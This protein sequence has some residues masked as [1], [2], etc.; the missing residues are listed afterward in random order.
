MYL[1][2]D[3]FKT[4]DAAADG[5]PYHSLPIQPMDTNPLSPEHLG[6]RKRGPA[7]D[8]EYTTNTAPLKNIKILPTHHHLS[9]RHDSHPAVDYPSPLPPPRHHHHH[10]RKPLLPLP[11]VFAHPRT[12][13]NSTNHHTRPLA[14]SRP[15]TT[16]TTTKP[17]PPPQTP[18]STIDLTPCHR[19]HRAPRQKR[20]LDNYSACSACG[21]RTCYICMRVCERRIGCVDRRRGGGSGGAGGSYDDG[22]GRRRICRECCVETGLEGETWCFEC[23]A[24]GE[25]GGGGGSEEEEGE[26]MVMG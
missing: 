26:G 14:V 4:T 20:D 22:D 9:P 19:C 7:G 1:T 12:H 25:M 18:S 21:A 16:A 13:R 10:H 6:K 23:V 8:H 11:R 3:I 2:D 17:P 24:V 5:H 15:T